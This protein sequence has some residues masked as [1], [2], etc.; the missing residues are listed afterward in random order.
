MRRQENGTRVR[1]QYFRHTQRGADPVTPILTGGSTERRWESSIR[2]AC[3]RAHKVDQS[4]V[5]CPLGR[6]PGVVLG[7]DVH[8]NGEV[9]AVGC[10]GCVGFRE[11][12]EDE[13]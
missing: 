6:C 8:G 3:S 4:E 1:T 2:S 5:I 7:R 9:S 13:H 12:S 11:R 10:G